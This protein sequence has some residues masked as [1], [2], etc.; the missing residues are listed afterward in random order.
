MPPSLTELQV[1]EVRGPIAHDP[2]D[3]VQRQHALV[4]HDRHVAVPGD[5]AE[6]VQVVPGRPAARRRPGRS[7]PGGRCARRRPAA[8]TPCWRPLPGSAPGPP[9][10]G[11]PDPL[12]VALERAEPHPDLQVRKPRAIAPAAARATSTPAGRRPEAP[13]ARQLLP[14]PPPEE[15]E[16]RHAIGPGRPGRGGRCRAPSGRRGSDD[17][18]SR[19]LRAARRGRADRARAGAAPGGEGSGPPPLRRVTGQVV[20]V[21]PGLAH[22]AHALVGLDPDVHLLQRPHGARG[23]CSNGA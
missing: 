9:P 5:V 12:D 7:G 13:V 14:D 6:A 15:L 11:P 2:D 8:P 10:R 1:E 4:G 3:V 22:S 19:G 21:P 18:A 17:G 23:E 16:D 20:G